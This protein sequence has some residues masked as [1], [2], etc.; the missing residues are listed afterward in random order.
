MISESL[1]RLRAAIPE[2]VALVAVSKFHPVE[3]MLQAYDAGQRIF[4]ESRPQELAAKVPKMPGD[5]QWHFIGHLQTNKLKL[6]LPYVCMV[7][8]VDSLHLLEAISAWGKANG[9]TVDVLLELHLG[10]EETKQG[11]TEEEIL[12]ILA[13]EKLDGIRIRGLMGMASNTDDMAVVDGEF[14]RIESLFLKIKSSGREGFDQLSIGM[15]S[16]W[17]LAIRHGATMVRIGTDIFGP[18]EY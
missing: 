11:F 6:V 3:R 12:S 7:Q 10:A 8:S 15:S 5:V 16:D 17:Q 1:E 13:S 4:A 9:R 2:G 18:R 14:D